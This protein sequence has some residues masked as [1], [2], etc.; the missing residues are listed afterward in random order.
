MSKRF[1]LLFF[2]FLSVAAYSQRYSQRQY[3]EPVESSGFRNGLDFSASAG[4]FFSLGLDYVASYQFNPYLQTGV[5]IG[6]QPSVFLFGGG[7]VM[8]PFYL[9]LRY[10]ILP[11]RV[12][13]FLGVK[14]GGIG[15]SEGRVFESYYYLSVMPG[16]RFNMGGRKSISLSLGLTSIPYYSYP[17]N[18]DPDYYYDPETETYQTVEE[19]KKWMFLSSLSFRVFY[20]F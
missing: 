17:D 3:R 20:Q 13:P 9:D 19:G 18:C 7:A 14:V 5:G 1:L 10:N 6:I 8:F 2:L 15:L 12:T 16:C 4:R 11:T